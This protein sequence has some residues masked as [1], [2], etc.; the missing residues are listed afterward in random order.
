M[1][2]S[3]EWTRF[4]LQAAPRCESKSGEDELL[5]G[6]KAE[7]LDPNLMKAMA[8][9][10]RSRLKEQER[11]DRRTLKAESVGYADRQCCGLTF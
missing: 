2:Q 10:V 5:A 1:L 11:S 6:I 4:D 7:L 9:Q 8:K 3:D